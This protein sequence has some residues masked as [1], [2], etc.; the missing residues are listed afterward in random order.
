[1][2]VGFDISGIDPNFKGHANRGIGRYVR[3]L[4]TYFQSI[5]G[6]ESLDDKKVK[7]SYFD[8]KS[9]ALPSF[10][11]KTLACLPLGKQTVR[12][13]LFYPLQ[14]ASGKMKDFDLLHFAAQTDAPSWC[15]K[16]FIISIHDIIPLVCSSSFKDAGENWRFKLAR[17]LELQSFNRAEHIIA[18]SES[19]AHDLER[20]LKIPSEKITVVHLGVDEKFFIAPN[21]DVIEIAR[22]K[23]R[24][25][26]GDKTLMYVGGI[27][28]NKNIPGLL[29]ILKDVVA[30][31]PNVRLIIAGKIQ[32]QKNY[33]EILDLIKNYNLEDNVSLPGYVSDDEL[34]ALYRICSV[35]VFSSLYEG[36][37]FPVCEAMAAGI[38]VVAANTS[39]IPEIAGD[40][41]LLYDPEKPSEGSRMVQEILNNENLKSTLKYEGPLQARKFPWSKTGEKTL[42]VYERLLS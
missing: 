21:K 4:H 27:D 8:Y 42:A 23:F 24:I 13:Q 41:C 11:D 30:S 14:L 33:Q 35:F 17:F 18:S 39:S 36:F 6:R 10:L 3:E 20:V 32:Q 26:Q 7:V 25:N 12:Q 15:P 31:I 5:E 2:K 34:M 40:S 37:G 28:P 29:Q 9:F 19:T 22:A 1:M 38:P 16:K